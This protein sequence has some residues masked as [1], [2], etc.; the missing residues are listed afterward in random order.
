MFVGARTADGR[1]ASATPPAPTASVAAA[2]AS[3]DRRVRRTGEPCHRGHRPGKSPGDATRTPS[4]SRPCPVTRA[5]G[6]FG[7]L[8]LEEFRELHG[9]DAAELL[10][11]DDR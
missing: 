4:P 11:V 7:P 6:D 10:R 5:S 3:M 8:L 9:H 2:P 1:C